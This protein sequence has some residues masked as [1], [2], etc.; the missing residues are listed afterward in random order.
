MVQIDA[1]E[2]EAEVGLMEV[3]DVPNAAEDELRKASKEGEALGTSEEED[4]DFLLLFD[5]IE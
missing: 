1:R 4:D 5:D 2:L 3:V